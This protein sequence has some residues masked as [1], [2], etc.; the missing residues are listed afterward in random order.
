[1]INKLIYKARKYRYRPGTVAL[2]HVGLVMICAIAMAPVRP[3]QVFNRVERGLG[4]CGFIDV[5]MRVCVRNRVCLCLFVGLRHRH[6]TSLS[7]PGPP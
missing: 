5:D 7:S 4:G 1:M 3:A 2:R 6:G